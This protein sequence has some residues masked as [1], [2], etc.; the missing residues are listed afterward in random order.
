MHYQSSRDSCHM[1][2]PHFFVSCTRRYQTGSPAVCRSCRASHCRPRA[3][4]PPPCTNQLHPSRNTNS[5]ATTKAP[6]GDAQNDCAACAFVQI[7]TSK[8]DNS[9]STFRRA[10]ADCVV[11]CAEADRAIAIALNLARILLLIPR[12]LARSVD[13]VAVGIA[14]ATILDGH[15]SDED[16]ALPACQVVIQ[17][18]PFACAARVRSCPPTQS[19][20]TGRCRTRGERRQVHRRSEQMSHSLVVLVP[21]TYSTSS[22][23]QGV[24]L[25]EPWSVPSTYSST[26]Q[27]RTFQCCCCSCS[28][29]NPMGADTAHP[30]PSWCSYLT[31]AR[32]MPGRKTRTH[33]RTHA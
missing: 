4:E 23:D 2:L 28:C 29:S 24:A 32:S 17:I 27:S 20:A 33:T 31:R 26:G 21:S 3:E 7:T 14:F 13:Q 30:L 15:V 12:A 9:Q 6:C 22:T 16:L 25:V 1:Y 10:L 18:G 8:Q 11:R 19:L 5:C